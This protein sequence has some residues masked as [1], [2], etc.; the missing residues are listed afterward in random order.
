MT[1]I[2]I[3]RDVLLDLKSSAGISMKIY[4][5]DYQR[6]VD[7]A[8]D[9]ITEENLHLVIIGVGR[10]PS[11]MQPI[12]EDIYKNTSLWLINTF[13]FFNKMCPVNLLTKYQIRETLDELSLKETENGR[14]KTELYLSYKEHDG[15]FTNEPAYENDLDLVCITTSTHD[16]S[17]AF[18]EIKFEYDRHEVIVDVHEI[19]RSDDIIMGYDSYPVKFDISNIGLLWLLIDSK[20]ARKI[21][22]WFWTK[23]NFDSTIQELEKEVQDNIRCRNEVLSGADEYL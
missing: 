5:R 16:L 6:Y 15:D 19:R 4:D 14:K 18:P 1:N 2:S 22:N 17:L 3:V 20:T 7:I 8:I 11:S 23:Y 10:D 12:H 9:E 21:P 13:I